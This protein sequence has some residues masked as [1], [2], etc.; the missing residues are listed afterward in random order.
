VKDLQALQ[1]AFISKPQTALKIRKN[2]FLSFLFL[3]EQ[4]AKNGINDTTKKSLF[5]PNFRGFCDNHF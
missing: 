1:R 4:F 2:I 3:L 5:E